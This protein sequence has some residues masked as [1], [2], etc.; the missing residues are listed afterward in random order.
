M[1]ADL[2]ENF[3]T[4]DM[5]GFWRLAMKMAGNTDPD[6]KA[7]LDMRATFTDREAARASRRVLL[8]WQPERIIIAHGRWY[9][10]NGTAELVRAF[11]W[12]D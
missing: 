11:R 5:H 1:L 6:G 4:G 2:I 10:E 8:D 3:E 12:L 7:P 9:P